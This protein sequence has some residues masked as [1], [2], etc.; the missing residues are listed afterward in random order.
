MCPTP[1]I[2]SW[3]QNLEGGVERYAIWC[4]LVECWTW[5]S[6]S[7]NEKEQLWAWEYMTEEG[8]H[9]LY[10]D[11]GEEIRS[12]QLSPAYHAMLICWY[13]KEKMLECYLVSCCIEIRLCSLQW[14]F[15]SF[16][17]EY[18]ITCYC[19]EQVLQFTMAL[20]KFYGWIHHYMLLY[21]TGFA[22]YNGTFK[23][24]WMNT[25]LHATV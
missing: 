23:V 24:L 7:S 13:S 3:F 22:V 4:V 8:K 14:H 20:L 1:P 11:I 17:D 16:K 6:L 2:S 21:R 18:I 12:L 9:D 19:I 15:R 25:S 5:L 10:I